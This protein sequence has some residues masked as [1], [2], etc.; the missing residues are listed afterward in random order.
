MNEFFEIWYAGNHKMAA[1]SDPS[2][3]KNIFLIWFSM[4]TKQTL[5]VFFKFGMQEISCTIHAFTADLV[6]IISHLKCSIGKI[7]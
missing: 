6:Y 3:T 1:V 5:T 2:R 4:T 7:N